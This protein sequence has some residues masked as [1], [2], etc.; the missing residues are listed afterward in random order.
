MADKQV[1]FTD[2]LN[3]DPSKASS[4]PSRSAAKAEWVDY[5]VAAGVE[6]SEAE[7]MSREQLIHEVGEPGPD[8]GGD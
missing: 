5:A 1:I 4:G 6:Q 2:R 7:K 3:I 8:A